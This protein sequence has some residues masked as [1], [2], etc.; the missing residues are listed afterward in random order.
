MAKKLL[1]MHGEEFP[2]LI[3][4]PHKRRNFSSIKHEEDYNLSAHP[5]YQELIDFLKSLNLKDLENNPFVFDESEF[6]SLIA[7]GLYMPFI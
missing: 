4:P 6:K 3:L 1:Y 2:D 7:Q 5:K